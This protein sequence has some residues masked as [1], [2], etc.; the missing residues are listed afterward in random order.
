M[1]RAPDSQ[2]LFPNNAVMA[3]TQSSHLFID[4]VILLIPISMTPV[5]FWQCE[6]CVFLV[7]QKSGHRITKSALVSMGQASN[8]IYS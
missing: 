4:D 5:Q 6:D 8:E 7:K 2:S 3:P 1:C